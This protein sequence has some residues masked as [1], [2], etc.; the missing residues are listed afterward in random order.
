MKRSAGLLTGFLFICCALQAQR[1]PSKL[2]AELS[3]GP[4]IPLGQFAEK[5]YRGPLEEDQ[6]GMAKT[7]LTAN[8]TAGYYLKENFGL[9]LIA[10]YS[11]NK[12]SEKGYKEYYK[13]GLTTPVMRGVDVETDNWKMF[14]IMAGGFFVTPLVE[15]KLNL[16]TKLSAGICKTAVP[17]HNW[18]IVGIPMSGGLFSMGWV[19]KEKLPAAFCYQ[20]S[21][22]LQYKVH[23]QV[24]LLF[25]VNSFNA[26]AQKKFSYYEPM[27]IWSSVPVIPVETNRKFKFGSVNALL[28][29][30]VRF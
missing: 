12:Q 25:E 22:G 15:N 1:K 18:A 11:S 9:L 16:V 28:G 13:A 29:V 6:P 14:K 4:S 26:T 27:G 5:S 10:G 8:F 21:L 23:K 30:G 3:F 20:V 17:E 24:N 19:G 7:G 2:F